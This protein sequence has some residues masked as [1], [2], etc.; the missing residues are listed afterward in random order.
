VI[1][2]EEDDLCS[3]QGDGREC[4]CEATS[5][6]LTSGGDRRMI[7]SANWEARNGRASD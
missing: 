1:A 4:P 3:D 2:V 7:A 5:G 6:R